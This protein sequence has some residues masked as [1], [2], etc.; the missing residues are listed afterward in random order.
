MKH[1]CNDS[2]RIISGVSHRWK[3]ISCLFF[4]LAFYGFDAGAA[5]YQ[6]V[7]VTFTIPNGDTEMLVPA[8]QGQLLATAAYGPVRYPSTYQNMQFM[9]FRNPSTNQIFYVQT[10]DPD[11]QVVDWQVYYD[12]TNYVLRLTMYSLGADFPYASYITDSTMTAAS[13]TEFYKKVARKYKSWAIEQTWAKRRISRMDHMATMAIAPD[14]R[15]VTMAND[16]SPYIDAW[17]GE[18]TS[19]WITF[20]R[21]Y[22]QYGI[23]GAVPDYRLGGGTESLNSLALLAGKNCDSYAYTNALLWDSNI[24]YTANPTT[25]LQTDMNEIWNNNPAARYDANNMIIDSSGQ[26]AAYTGDPHMKYI[27]QSSAA[28]KTTFLNACRDMAAAGWKGIYFDMAAFSPPVL[29]YAQNHGHDQ[30]DPLVWQNGIRD[31]LNTLK[32]DPQTGNLV[33]FTEGNAEIYMDLV[34]GYLAY[35]ETG[36]VDTTSP[37]K[38]QVPLFRE[39]YGEIARFVGWQV[40][41]I[42]NPAK[43]MD[44]LTPA[45][46]AG[47]VKKAANFGSLGHASPAFINWGAYKQVQIKLATDSAYAS[48]FDLL[49]NPISRKV[50]EQGGGAANWVK[51]GTAPDLLNVV[52][53]QTGTAAVQMGIT[54]RDGGAHYDLNIEESGLLNIISWD[55]KLSSS[56]YIDVYVKASNNNY[57]Y[58]IYDPHAKNYRSYSGSYIK[59]GLGADT[60]DGKWRTVCRDLN[61]DLKSAYPALTVTKVVKVLA[62]A[63]GLMD[64]IALSNTNQSY[65]DGTGVANWLATGDGIAATSATDGETG[66]ASIQF[67]GITHRD[68]GKYFTR[69][70]SDSQR[71]EMSWDMKT[72]MPYYV[73]ITVAAEGGYWYNLLYDQNASDYRFTS[74]S[75]VKIGLGTE[76]TD[77]KWRTFRRNLA[78]DLYEG[79]GLNITSVVG[80]RV[81]A[82]ASIDNVTLLGNGLR[83]A[84]GR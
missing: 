35:T 54:N 51:V 31:V 76:T 83:T 43:T 32:T 40:L 75:T 10:L 29:C 52:D 50:Y 33:I 71:Y 17:N 13:Q 47:S 2:S 78:D 60:F 46:L 62:F 28:W 77:G 14:L 42:T 65:E 30:A 74:G 1:S 16:V 44:D 48:L 36:V 24:A 67:A 66:S 7:S 23:D 11:G 38:K 4:C 8:Y 12:G 45:L 63:N 53:S 5:T 22:W 3:T 39:V 73:L 26:V 58:L 49:N 70:I 25:Q 72:S 41:P 20:W 9:A 37:L 15:N 55:M 18:R 61:A 34:D 59:I 21:K 69:T 6:P 27:C 56:Y 82:T 68:G 57:Y 64:N 80:M 19:C 79:T 84:G 81:Y